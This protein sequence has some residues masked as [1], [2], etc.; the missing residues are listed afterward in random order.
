MQKTL[1]FEQPD[2]PPHFEHMFELEHEAFGLRFP[3]RNLWDDATGQTRRDMID[4][5]M[6]IYER[7]LET[8]HWD[9]LAVFWPWGDPEGIREAQRRFGSD[10]L[11]GSVVG[12]GLWCIDQITDWEQFAL[13]LAEN[14]SVLHEEAER[15]CLDALRR[16]D[17]LV[18]AGAE[19]ISLLHDVAHNDGP[20]CSPACFDRLVTPYLARLVERVKDRG[21]Y[22]IVHSDGNLMLILE[23]ILSTQ[24]HVLHS[25]DPMAGMDI[26]EIKRLT[27][28][29][30][31][32]LMGNV[33]CDLLQHGPKEAIE[34]EVQYCMTHGSPGGGY[35]FSTSNTIYEGMPL[36][37]YEQMLAAYREF[38]SA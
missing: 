7:I 9:A 4:Q 37:H 26:A 21:A 8:Y 10:I 32:A 17:M 28:H 25:L 20:F 35:I 31:V 30:R 29:R 23:S 36:E 11:I 3:D 33:R 38:V 14:E 16:I 27:Y 19:Q 6:R 34:K 15:R 13:D 5:C 1:R 24:P 2:R 22:C 12:G 18:D